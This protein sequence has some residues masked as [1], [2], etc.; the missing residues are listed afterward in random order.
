MIVLK[1]SKK[2]ARTMIITVC[3]LLEAIAI[4]FALANKAKISV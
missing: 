2:T 4:I 1:V 3:G